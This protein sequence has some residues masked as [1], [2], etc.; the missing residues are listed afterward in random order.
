MAQ[1]LGFTQE[2]TIDRWKNNPWLAYSLSV[3]ITLLGLGCVHY[4]HIPNPAIALMI[5]VVFSSFWTGFGGGILSGL[6]VMAYCVDFLLVNGKMG[7]DADENLRRLIVLI[8]SMG[9]MVLMVGTL[10]RLLAHRTHELELAVRQLVLLSN[11]DYLTSV[12]N[13]QFFEQTVGREWFRNQRAKLPISLLLLDIDCFHKYNE[14]Y[15][16][17]EGD[18]CIRKLAGVLAGRIQRPSDLVARYG[19]EEFAVLLPDTQ[20]QGAL[21][22]ARDIRRLIGELRIASGSPEGKRYLTVSI[23]IAS[24]T[25]A[26][27]D[28]PE[29][30]VKRAGL[31]LIEAK[32]AGGDA[33]QIYGE[34][35]SDP[36]QE[37]TLAQSLYS[38]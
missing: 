27:T 16:N 11:V 7:Q 13:R 14:T 10:K 15:G 31:A 25:P 21:Q 12:A 32:R 1:W 38:G 2:A 35:Q 36:L 34:R 24:E 6:I 22:V 20:I 30:F 4:F 19:G 23:G 33:V 26:A 18:A 17:L 5:A 29:D 9:I 3:A 28:T 8:L 37:T